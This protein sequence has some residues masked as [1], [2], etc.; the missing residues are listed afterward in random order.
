MPDDF[1]LSWHWTSLLLYIYKGNQNYRKWAS[2]VPMWGNVLSHHGQRACPCWADLMS[3]VCPI[4]WCCNTHIPDFRILP[5]HAIPA[6]WITHS[7]HSF[8]LTIPHTWQFLTPDNSFHQPNHPDNRLTIARQA[9]IYLSGHYS[10]KPD[11]LTVFRQFLVL[12]KISDMGNF[13]SY[14]PN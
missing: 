9:T 12:L 13:Y 10:Q 7:W 8:H 6:V 11:N 5:A 1:R 4:S 14:R 3:G 2:S